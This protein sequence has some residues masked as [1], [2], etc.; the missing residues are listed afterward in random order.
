VLGLVAALLAVTPADARVPRATG[1][2][3]VITV[4]SA[5]IVRTTDR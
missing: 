3:A 4:K 2:N 5:A 1:D